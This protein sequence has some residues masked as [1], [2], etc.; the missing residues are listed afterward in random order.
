[1][2]WAAGCE[3]IGARLVLF[4]S[5]RAP[6]SSRSSPFMRLIN[7]I[8]LLLASAS[9]AMS[10]TQTPLPGDPQ[11]ARAVY[12]A[13]LDTLYSLF[14]ER[15]G[16]IVIFNRYGHVD[17]LNAT[18]TRELDPTTVA[19]YEVVPADEDS[20]PTDFRYRLPTRILTTDQLQRLEIEGIPLAKKAAA[21]P[22]LE[23]ITPLWR[24]FAKK[25][26]LAWGYVRMSRV[27]FNRDRTEALVHTSHH[28]GEMCLS[29]ATWVVKRASGS[30]TIVKR[31]VQ[32]EWLG[33]T[34]ETLRY[35]GRDA[36]P[37]VNRRR[38]VNGTI[39]NLATG[40]P[41]PN[42]Y[43]NLA[44]GWD[45]ENVRTDAR[46]RYVSTKLPAVEG[47]LFMKTP[48]PI[49]GRS[50]TMVVGLFTLPGRTDTTINAAVD[51][52]GCRYL[53]RAHPLI[54]NRTRPLA[55]PVRSVSE[56]VAGVYRGV[57]DA[58]FPGKA[59]E[60]IL[61]EN[62][63]PRWCA[64]CFDIEAEVPRLVRQGKL[65]PS[66]ETDFEKVARDSAAIP[67]F[68]YRKRIVRLSNDDQAPLRD[69]EYYNW[70]VIRVA[71]PGSHAIVSLSGVAFN[72]SLTEA[73]VQ[74]HVDS[75]KKSEGDEAEVMVL[76]KSAAK[77]RVSLRH[78]GERQTSGE[79]S[80]GKCEPTDAPARPPGRGAVRQLA[81]E[82]NIVR[83]GTS[84][85]VRGETK[86][87]RMLLEPLATHPTKP[88]EL[89][90]NAR[91][92][93]ASG[94]PDRRIVGAFYFAGTAA[95]MTFTERLPAGMYDPHAWREYYEILRTDGTNFF[96][97]WL[98]YRELAN[99]PRGYFCATPTGPAPKTADIR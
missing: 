36:D 46:G 31:I 12:H 41:L 54:A 40:K 58:L 78:A 74:V 63:T 6:V 69:N 32:H 95:G 16:V 84:R 71:Y 21:Q 11:H 87:L 93:D 94:S 62:F 44:I 48:C 85:A 72:D 43:L 26:P 90:A 49:P 45:M 98:D 34:L 56:D 13:V 5:L 50:D 30:W 81:G 59:P 2:R 61:L 1:M 37:S 14:G 65:D 66:T 9:T 51:Y 55:A 88:A 24:A 96:G 47:G 39:T 3:E 18:Q 67:A 80:A 73:L 8:L 82:F 76:R 57:L 7:T 4:M 10:Q 79:L 53:D 97:R 70:E 35:V 75:A 52:R 38:E 64:H 23:G 89:V 17:P 15:P 25:Y 33:K 77:W 28:C 83:V 29:R 99:P 20:L 86:V 68:K 27:A 92:L 60:P 19:A 22:N 91:M 42:L